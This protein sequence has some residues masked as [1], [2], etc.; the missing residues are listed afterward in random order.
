MP[1]EESIDLQ[2]RALN[3]KCPPTE[4]CSPQSSPQTLVI[5]WLDASEKGLCS[6]LAKY[7]SPDRSAIVTDYC[8]STQSYMIDTIVVRDAAG[9]IAGRPNLKE[10]RMD[11][12]LRFV[13]H[14]ENGTRGNWRILVEYLG[15]KWYVFDGYH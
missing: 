2:Q 1:V 12:K 14:G 7:T 5:A 13:L 6:V 11:G 15:G 10:V 4:D 3:A 8:S 9:R